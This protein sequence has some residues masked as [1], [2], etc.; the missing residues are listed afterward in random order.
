MAREQRRWT[1]IVCSR[2]RF[3]AAAASSFITLPLAVSA[4]PAVHVARIG[5]LGSGSYERVTYEPFIQGLRDLGWVQGQNVTIDYRFADGSIERLPDLA[6]ELA[7]RKVDVIVAVATPSSLAAKHATKTIPVVM[8]GAGDPVAAGLVTN[9]ARPDGNV[10]GLSFDVS[11]ESFTKSLELFKQA[12]PTARRVAVLINPAN[13]AQHHAVNNLGVAAKQLGVH[14]RVLQARGP[15]DFDAA[16]TAMSKEGF[17]GLLVVTDPTFVSNRTRLAELA[18]KH[19]MPSIH[20]VRA[21]VEAGGLM[22]YGP[23]MA[24]LYRRASTYVDKLLKGA[25][26]RDLPVEQ[27]SKFELVVN[28][29]AARALG[30]TIPQSLRLRADEVIQ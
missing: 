21:Y 18:L 15:D 24:V 12:A 23:N 27:P 25:K 16:F 3:L 26:P 29:K 1:L 2:R 28:L 9:L 22:S 4:Q 5:F 19:H 11:L 10:T 6:V 14:L 7:Q 13:P 30:I 20:G 17:D 8:V